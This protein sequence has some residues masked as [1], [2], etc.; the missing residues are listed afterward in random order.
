MGLAR[1]AR[2]VKRVAVVTPIRTGGQRVLLATSFESGLDRLSMPQ[3]IKVAAPR[4]RGG[5]HHRGRHSHSRMK[6]CGTAKA[7][8]DADRRGGPAPRYTPRI[9][10]PAASPWCRHAGATSKIGARAA[11]LE[12][13][14]RKLIVAAYL[15]SRGPAAIHRIRCT[16]RLSQITNLEHRGADGGRRAVDTTGGFSPRQLQASLVSPSLSNKTGAGRR[17]GTSA[18]AKGSAGRSTRAAAWISSAPLAKW[19]SRCRRPICSRISRRLVAYV[20]QSVG[21]VAHPSVHTDI[22]SWFANAQAN[23]AKLQP[24]FPGT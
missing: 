20:S 12:T 6:A 21:A 4:G 11:I 23:P 3:A 19:L 5:A 7:P 15:G 1:F 24:E 17:I 2:C 18:V 14:M 13:N 16:E 8:M 10:A 9:E 22:R